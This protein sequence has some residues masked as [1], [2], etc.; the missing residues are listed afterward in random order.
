M[1]TRT[2]KLQRQREKD[3]RVWKVTAKQAVDVVTWNLCQSLDS[4]TAIATGP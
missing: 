4:K 2:R 3:H 1:L